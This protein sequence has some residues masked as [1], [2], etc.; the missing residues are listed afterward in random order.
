MLNFVLVGEIM[1]GPG[2]RYRTL[3]RFPGQELL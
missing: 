2:R 1:V 3:V